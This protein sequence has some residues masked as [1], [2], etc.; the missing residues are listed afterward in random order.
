MQSSARAI[1]PA[2]AP[3]ATLSV[4]LWILTGARMK[5]EPAENQDDPAEQEKALAR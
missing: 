4:S 1:K 5:A 3:V 2:L